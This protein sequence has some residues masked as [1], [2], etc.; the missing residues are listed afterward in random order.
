M[1]YERVAACARRQSR[2]GNQEMSGKQVDFATAAWD[3]WASGV[4]ARIKA[5]Q[6]QGQKVRLM[7]LGP[8]FVEP[9]WCDH[10]HAGYVVT[11]QYITDLDGETWMMHAGQGFILPPGTR[12]RSRNTGA[13]PAIVFVVDLEA[14]APAAPTDGAV[15]S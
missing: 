12:H 1:R 2:E 13:M 5:A 8:G 4:P 11:G 10:G 6:E 3:G 15:V 7:E 9:Q 14:P